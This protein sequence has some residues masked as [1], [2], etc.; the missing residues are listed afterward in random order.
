MP[1]R[2]EL[3]LHVV[4]GRL[5]GT[6]EPRGKIGERLALWAEAAMANAP[7]SVEFTTQICSPPPEM[8]AGGMV[9]AAI[10]TVFAGSEAEGR[11]ILARLGENTPE[12]ALHIMEGVPT[13]FDVL[14]HLTAQSLPERQHAKRSCAK[15][16][17]TLNDAKSILSAR[18]RCPSWHPAP[19]GQGGQ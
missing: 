1:L 2:I 10:A 14:Y 3:K 19:A 17:Q 18:F 6:I 4:D 8:P 12:G 5:L 15:Y 13:P 9:L 16:S 11:A 7:A